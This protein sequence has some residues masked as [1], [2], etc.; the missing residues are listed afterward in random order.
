MRWWEVKQFFHF[1]KGKTQINLNFNYNI[2]APQ[3]INSNSN[4]NRDM[5]LESM[6]VKDTQ[7][8][9]ASS[10][11]CE[12]SLE[13][14]GAGFMSNSVLNP[15]PMSQTSMNSFVSSR[16]ITLTL[17][18]PSSQTTN[19]SPSSSSIS[20]FHS[21]SSTKLSTCCSY[22]LISSYS[23][24]SSLYSSV[25]LQRKSQGKMETG[26]NNFLSQIQSF[27]Q[28]IFAGSLSEYSE[29]RRELQS[30]TSP[31]TSGFVV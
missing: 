9:K 16:R 31:S 25:L 14:N 11:I 28:Y 7:L 10:S 20:S 21:C 30:S 8:P 18:F 2:L 19:S 22:S 4:I 17:N 13:G 23:S 29:E 5:S 27:R 24:P 1:P 15:Q 6:V 12:V 3:K 26:E